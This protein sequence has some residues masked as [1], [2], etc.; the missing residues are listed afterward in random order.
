MSDFV[1]DEIVREMRYTHEQ[2][3][4]FAD[5][6]DGKLSLLLEGGAV[7]ITA[8]SAMGLVL[9]SPWYYWV[10][11]CLVAS[12][13]LGGT[14]YVLGHWAPWRYPF[15]L[16][17]EWTALAEDYMVLTDDDMRDALV[18]QYVDVIQDTQD[19]LDKKASAV[20]VGMVAIAV[21]LLLLVLLQT[22]AVF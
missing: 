8:F 18:K 10:G 6:V 14:I 11:L 17:A 9:A 15:P 7:I 19:T 1:M 22:V 20:T 4:G 2:L 5:A 3:L 16:V 12:V 21:S 13:Y